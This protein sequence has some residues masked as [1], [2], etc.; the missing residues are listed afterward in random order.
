[1]SHKRRAGV[2]NTGNYIP[3][4]LAQAYF[5]IHTLEHQMFA[6]IRA[7][8]NRIESVVV[9]GEQRIGSFLVLK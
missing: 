3:L 5:L 8:T 2:N 7:G 6:V 4:M 1:M 9:N